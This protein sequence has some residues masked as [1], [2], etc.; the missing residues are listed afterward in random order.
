V[1]DQRGVE[2][3]LHRFAP[4]HDAGPNRRLGDVGSKIAQLQRL[5]G[6]IEIDRVADVDLPQHVNGHGHP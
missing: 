4:Q 6:P 1:S 2:L 5:R 3:D